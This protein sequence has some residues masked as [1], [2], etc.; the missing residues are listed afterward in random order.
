MSAADRRNPSPEEIQR[1]LAQ[2]LARG[3]V[4]LCAEASQCAQ[5]RA[6]QQRSGAPERQEWAPRAAGEGP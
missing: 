4:R 2:I 1:E 3:Y 5:S 6:S